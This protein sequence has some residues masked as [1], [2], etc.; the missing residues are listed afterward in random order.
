MPAWQPQD[1][2]GAY[3]VSYNRPFDG[4]LRTDSGA[5]YLYYAEYQMMCWLEKNGYNVS[6]T[7]AGRSRQ[8]RPLLTNHKVFMSS[9]H[10]EYW[11]ASQRANVVKRP[12]KRA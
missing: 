7:S 6:Y 4:A 2:K 10:D 5:S 8:S 1:Y 9:G 3:A 12:A 11:S